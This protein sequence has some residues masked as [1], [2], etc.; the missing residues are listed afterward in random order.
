MPSILPDVPAHDDVTIT[1]FEADHYTSAQLIVSVAGRL[2]EQQ[3]IITR[4][5]LN[6]QTIDLSNYTNGVYFVSVVTTD[7]KITTRFVKN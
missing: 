2:V 5:G 3:T 4:K 1:T 7:A 6:N